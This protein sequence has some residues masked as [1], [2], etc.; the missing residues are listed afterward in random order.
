LSGSFYWR[1]PGESEPEGI[2]RRLATGPKLPLRFYLEAGLMEDQ[3]HPEGGPSLLTA[4]R[5]LRTVL[6]AKGYAVDYREFNGGHSI[7]SWRDSLAEGLM[8]LFG[9]APGE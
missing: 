1:P 8:A 3:P 9:R 7:L 5:H 2:T 4:K 6:Q